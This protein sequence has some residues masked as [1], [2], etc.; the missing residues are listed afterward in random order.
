MRFV[1]GTVPLWAMENP[2]KVEQ[3][4]GRS[5]TFSGGLH[6]SVNLPPSYEA[7]MNTG[8]SRTHFF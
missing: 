4:L 5:H 6:L 3:A 8:D 1:A 2:A 7:M